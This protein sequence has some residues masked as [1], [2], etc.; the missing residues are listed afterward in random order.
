MI[1]ILWIVPIAMFSATI[2]FMIASLCAMAD[3][4][5]EEP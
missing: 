1:S 4:E 2:G 3:D 5:S